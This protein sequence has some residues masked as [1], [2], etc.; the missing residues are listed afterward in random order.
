MGIQM[1]IGLKDEAGAQT[2]LHAVDAYKKRL[3]ASIER[4]KRRLAEFEHRYQVTTTHFLQHMA[5]EDLEGGDLDYVTWAGE[6]KILEGLETEL[7]ELE[8]ASYQLPLVCSR[9]HQRPERG[10]SI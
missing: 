5:S 1:V 4:T 6:V 3:Q 7:E 9:H 8:N 2:V 10:H